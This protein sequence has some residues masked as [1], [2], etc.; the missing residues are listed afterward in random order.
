MMI[1]VRDRSEDASLLLQHDCHPDVL[2]HV[3][4][5]GAAHCPGL[6]TQGD[7]GGMVAVD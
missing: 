5:G 2:V 1:V 6:Q 4:V 3:H 7:I